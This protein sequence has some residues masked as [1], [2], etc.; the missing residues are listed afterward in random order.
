ML[1]W[2]NV[3]AVVLVM[4]DLLR[5]FVCLLVGFVLL[6]VLAREMRREKGEI[7][8]LIISKIPTIQFNPIII[9]WDS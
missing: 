2:K 4:S 5:M 7:N 3:A 6:V 1:W 8:Q 9:I